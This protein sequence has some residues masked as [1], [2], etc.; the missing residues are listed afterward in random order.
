MLEFIAQALLL[1]GV[2]LDDLAERLNAVGHPLGESGLQR[3]QLVVELG[4][5]DP[6]C[7]KQLGLAQLT[8]LELGALGSCWSRRLLRL[9]RIQPACPALGLTLCQ[10]REYLAYSYV[11]PL[12][13]HR[14][15]LL[16]RQRVV[17]KPTRQ[18]LSAH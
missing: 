13:L 18:L 17:C 3:F 12:Q 14:Q 2:F 7:S 5:C 16:A 10:V 8:L 11:L 4:L 6:S 9:V 1:F 15:L